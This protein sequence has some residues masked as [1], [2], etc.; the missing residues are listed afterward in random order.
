[1]RAQVEDYKKADAQFQK[2]KHKRELAEQKLKFKV[3]V[4]ANNRE[5]LF[6]TVANDKYIQQVKELE[7]TIL[8][9]KNEHSESKIKVLP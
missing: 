6:S 3:D 7:Q 9:Q 5:E 1:L 2:D 4:M 8:T